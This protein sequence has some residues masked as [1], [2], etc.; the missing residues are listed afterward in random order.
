MPTLLK[1]KPWQ[2]GNSTFIDVL[3]FRYT[4]TYFAS[5]PLENVLLTKMATLDSKN[6]TAC[7]ISH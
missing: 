2:L 6:R 1:V 5:G 4:L 3:L 7:T